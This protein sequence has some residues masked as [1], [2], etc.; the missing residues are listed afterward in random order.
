MSIVTGP[1]TPKGIVGVCRARMT[2][3]DGC[4]PP[5][6]GTV[7]AGVVFDCIAELNMTVEQ[8]TIPEIERT[9][10]AGEKVCWVRPESKRPKMVKVTGSL[11][12]YDPESF[13]AISGGTILLADTGPGGGGV[14]IPATWQG[15]AVGAGITVNEEPRIVAL[16][17]WQQTTAAP[18]DGVLCTSGDG[19]LFFRHVFPGGRVS[20]TGINLTDDNGISLAFEG[21]FYANP[22]FLEGAW[23]DWVPDTP[24]GS[25]MYLNFWDPGMPASAV[26]M[27]DAP[28]CP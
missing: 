3:L 7:F 17:I 26:G 2:F 23:G 4:A 11:G 8:R 24:A 27:I 16:E 21:D 12:I 20:F 15:K 18:E 9:S 13:A 1:T 6:C 22:A 19:D 25:L 10:C 28:A 5:E 14:P